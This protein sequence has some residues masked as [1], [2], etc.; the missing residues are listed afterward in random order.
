MLWPRRSVRHVP[1]TSQADAGADGA[2]LGVAEQI[3][4]EVTP[5]PTLERTELPLALLA[6]SVVGAAPQAEA[7]A[8][9]VEVAATVTS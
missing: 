9:Q 2:P 5:S 3:A 8:S 7:P 4:A 1:S 6:P